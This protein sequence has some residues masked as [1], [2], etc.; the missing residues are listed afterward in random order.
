MGEA[1][2][3]SSDVDRETAL[4]KINFISTVV[5]FITI[6]IG[7]VGNVLS[8]VVLTRPKMKVEYT[9]LLLPVTSE[10]LV[11]RDFF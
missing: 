9:V 3:S 1:E 2:L 8:L 11:S 6:A 5:M 4:E 10:S 7:I